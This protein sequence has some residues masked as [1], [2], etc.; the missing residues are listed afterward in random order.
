MVK[1]L[2]KFFLQWQ[3][4]IDSVEEPKIDEGEPAKENI[5]PVIIAKEDA[6]PIIFMI[7]TPK[8]TLSGMKK[9]MIKQLHL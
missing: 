6:K 9:S 1:G 2:K 3:K 4:S 5:K 8:N 7:T